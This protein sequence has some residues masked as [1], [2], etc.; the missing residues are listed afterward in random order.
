MIR[1]LIVNFVLL[2][3]EAH[4]FISLIPPLCA[5]TFYLVVSSTLIILLVMHLFIMLVQNF[6]LN[7]PR[8]LLSPFNVTDAA[9]SGFL[10]LN[11]L[12]SRCPKS[13]PPRLSLIV[14]TCFPYLPSP[15]SHISSDTSIINFLRLFCS[16]VTLFSIIP[17]FFPTIYLPLPSVYAVPSAP[18]FL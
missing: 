12:C 10:Y 11:F 1:L 8:S 3:W 15:S 18:L 14:S 5:S 2:Y 9:I 17:D 13:T 7:C 4:Y 6:H 16:L